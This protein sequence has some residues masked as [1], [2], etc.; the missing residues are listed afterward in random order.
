MKREKERKEYT[1]Q[2]V[3]PILACRQVQASMQAGAS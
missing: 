3:R 2:T 1:R